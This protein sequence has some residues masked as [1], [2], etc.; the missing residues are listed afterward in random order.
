MPDRAAFSSIISPIHALPVELLAEIFKLTIRDPTHIKDAFRVSQVCVDWRQ[1][2][3][4]TPRLWTEPIRVDLRTRSHDLD[5][6]YADGLK[7]WLTRSTPLPVPISFIPLYT[8]ISSRVLEVV[9]ALAPRWRSLQVAGAGEFLGDDST[10]LSL[11]SQLARSSLDCL[12]E[13]DLG[14][15]DEDIDP[16]SI[17]S[18]AT[19]PRLRKLS[20][21]IHPQILVPWAQLTDLTLGY[22]SPDIVINTL[23]QCPNLT[24]ASVCTSRWTGIPEAGRG[25]FAFNHLHTLTVSFV[26]KRGT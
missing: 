3:Q 20:M 23:A 17:I 24:G 6:V 12:E 5:Q 16:S 15:F 14:Q 26:E 19:I 7:A 11:V 25:I 2:A 13:L 22:A 21:D 8:N 10:P 9:L 18:F 1:I 4:T